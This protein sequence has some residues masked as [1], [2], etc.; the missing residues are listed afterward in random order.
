[1]NMHTYNRSVILVTPFQVPF[2]VGGKYSPSWQE[3][4]RGTLDV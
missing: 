4:K 1:M 2:G 3:K